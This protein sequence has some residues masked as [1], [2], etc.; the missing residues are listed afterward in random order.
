M[1]L[2]F[3]YLYNSHSFLKMSNDCEKEYVGKYSINLIL[4]IIISKFNTFTNNF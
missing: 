1:E 2:I 4:L 3:V